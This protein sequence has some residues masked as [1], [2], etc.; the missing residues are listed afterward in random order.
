MPTAVKEASQAYQEESDVIGRFFDEC[1]IQKELC[2]V[3][4]SKL[5]EAYDAWC[6]KS[7]EHAHAANKFG[8][9][10]KKRNQFGKIKKRINGKSGWVWQ[11]IGL[12]YDG[13]VPN[14]GT[15]IEHSHS[16]G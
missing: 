7:G 12:L 16:R 2:E 5:Y 14:S 13:S 9:Q 11:R 1:C 3:Q 4:A 15:P 8:Q 10:V 6:Q